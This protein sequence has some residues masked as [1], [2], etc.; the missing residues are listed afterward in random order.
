MTRLHSV[1]MNIPTERITGVRFGVMSPEDIIR[2][3]VAPIGTQEMFEGDTPKRCGL[4]DPRMGVLDRRSVCPT[5]KQGNIACPGYHG[6][7]ELAMPVLHKQYEKYIIKILRCVCPMCSYPR[8]D[9]HDPGNRE[10]LMSASGATRLGRFVNAAQKQ[11]FCDRCGNLLP[12]KVRGDKTYFHRLQFVYKGEEGGE[13]V[14]RVQPE[15]VQRIMRGITDEDCRYLGLDPE[16]CRPE[17]LV[18][19]VVLVPPPSMRPPVRKNA[20]LPMHDD[21]TFT[22]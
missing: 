1:T 13:K 21:L 18:C 22:H 8:L 11:K 12:S 3:S 9:V 7:I 17:W 4:F 14:V 2:G 16:T 10:N 20:Q 19:S 15:D 6:H 5:D